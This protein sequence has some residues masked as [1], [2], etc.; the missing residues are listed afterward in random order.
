MHEYM[1]VIIRVLYWAKMR[2]TVIMK[3]SSLSWTPTVSLLLLFYYY[4]WYTVCIDTVPV[5]EYRNLRETFR[6]VLADFAVFDRWRYCKVLYES[7]RGK[8]SKIS[9]HR[10]SSVKF[11][12]SVQWW[13][14]G[15]QWS[16]DENVAIILF[17]P[18]IPLSKGHLN[19]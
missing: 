18:D 6:K 8:W 5:T 1:Y 14:L 11:S 12:A 10:A 15:P 7:N 9:S 2:Q 19:E 17:P 16:L 13:I 3:Y 4:A